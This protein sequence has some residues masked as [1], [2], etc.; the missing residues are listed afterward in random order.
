MLRF[1]VLATQ[2]KYLLKALEGL[3]GLVI[4]V[5]PW[6]RESV[7]GTVDMTFFIVIIDLMPFHVLFELF[8]LESKYFFNN[9]VYF[10]S[11]EFDIKLLWF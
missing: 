9:F 6:E 8:R 2:A 5:S 11:K 1:A 7:L 3:Q 10:F 4:L